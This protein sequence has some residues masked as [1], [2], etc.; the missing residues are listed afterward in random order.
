MGSYKVLK[1]LVYTETKDEVLTAD[2]YLPEGKKD[3]PCM[4]MLHG[5]GWRYGN[6]EAY[7][8]WGHAL[9]ERGICAMSVNYRLSTL[10]YAGWPDAVQDVVDAMQFLVRKAHEWDL[11]PYNMGMMGDSSGAHLGFMAAF[12]R[13]YASLKIRLLIGAYGVYDVYD[14]AAYGEDRW[15][16]KQLGG[17]DF[18]GKDLWRERAVFDE[19]SPYYQ[20]E[21]VVKSYPLFKPEIMLLWGEQDG[22][23]PCEQSLEF[24]KKLDQLKIPYE[25]IAIPD[26]GHLWFPRDIMT[27]R[28]NLLDRY[29]LSE[30]APKVFEFIDRV[31]SKPRFTVPE[32][33][34]KEHYQESPSYKIA[35]RKR[36]PSMK[37]GG[38]E[39]VPVHYPENK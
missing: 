6:S 5:G 1:N 38:L 18:I 36:H 31:F 13:E 29:P 12:R 8:E 14:W 27:N 35:C 17:R 20:I 28:I 21:D 33:L 4:L 37:T 32:P 30:V 3:I 2:I 16:G 39:W 26:A 7:T 22:F 34:D 10:R 25:A 15:P 24:A 11:D 19:A 23:V 9:A